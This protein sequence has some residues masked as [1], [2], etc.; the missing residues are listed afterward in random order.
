[1]PKFFRKAVNSRYPRKN[2]EGE[3]SSKGA[4]FEIAAKKE[5]L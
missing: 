4:T 5:A 2:K 3:K 1:L